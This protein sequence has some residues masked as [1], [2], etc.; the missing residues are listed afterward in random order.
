MLAVSLSD[1]F[2]VT[3]NRRDVT[4][5]AGD[6]CLT[7]CS[8]PGTYSQSTFSGVPCARL[9]RASLPPPLRSVAVGYPQPH[10]F[11]IALSRDAARELDH[12]VMEPVRQKLNG[13]TKLFV[14]SDGDLNLIDFSSLVD[15]HGDELIEKYN[16]A[17]LTSGRDLVRLEQIALT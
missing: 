14:A 5:H 1:T 9:P 10:L 4:L 6:V 15:E 2:V 12:L 11:V 8:S 17:G 3:Q 16:I 7:T 13:Q